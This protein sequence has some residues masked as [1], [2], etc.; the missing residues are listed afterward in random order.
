M[1]RFPPQIAR[2]RM[3]GTKWRFR[4]TKNVAQGFG[5]H[6][7]N[8]LTLSVTRH[9]IYYPSITNFKYLEM[10]QIPANVMIYVLFSQHRLIWEALVN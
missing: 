1:R 4:E 10:G 3:D 8:W 5:I 7:F 6:I 9:D 2:T